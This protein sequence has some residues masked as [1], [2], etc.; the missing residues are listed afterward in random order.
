[1]SAYK[2]GKLIFLFAKVQLCGDKLGLLR[3]F[4]LACG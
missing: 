1:M 2:M 4:F 3:Y